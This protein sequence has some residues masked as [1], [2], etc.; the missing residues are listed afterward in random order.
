MATFEP[1]ASQPKAYP[2]SSVGHPNGSQHDNLNV[3]AFAF[4]LAE[5]YDQR[6]T[7][8]PTLRSN[9]RRKLG[10]LAVRLPMSEP[11][12]TLTKFVHRFSFH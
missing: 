11:G 3:P 12:A 6:V 7:S 9:F 4:D 10:G 2:D 5:R 1:C 8:C